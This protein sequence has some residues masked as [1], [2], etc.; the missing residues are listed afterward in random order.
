[1]M[2]NSKVFAEAKAKAMSEAELLLAEQSD[3]VMP[4][5]AEKFGPELAAAQIQLES[6]G[7]REGID[8]FFERLTL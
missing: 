7:L 5:M 1:M 3:R 4:W 6:E 2:S 8:K